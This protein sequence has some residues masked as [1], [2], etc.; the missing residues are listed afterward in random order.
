M[1]CAACSAVL[2]VI[3]GPLGVGKSTTS[4][5]LLQL[6]LPREHASSAVQGRCF[7]VEGDYSLVANDTDFRDESF[8][9]AWV[10]CVVAQVRHMLLSHRYSRVVINYVFERRSHL[11]SLVDALRA[12]CSE[13]CTCA[14]QSTVRRTHK[15]HINK[16][17]EDTNSPCGGASGA[18]A[19]ASGAGA[20][21]GAGDT[22]AAH[23][24]KDASDAGTDTVPRD[25]EAPLAGQG[26]CVLCFRLD[27]TEEF[28]VER[29]VTR[30]TSQAEW[31]RTRCVELR[32]VLSEA[33]PCG[34]LGQVVDTTPC[35][36][37]LAG[38]REGHCSAAAVAGKLVDASL[39]WIAPGHSPALPKRLDFSE[40]YV[41]KVVS[42]IKTATTRLF[43]GGVG[44]A[45]QLARGD[46]A[47]ASCRQGGF[48]FAVLGI[49]ARHETTMDKL[50]EEVAIRD[51]FNSADDLRAALR[52]HYAGIKHTDRVV[53]F[54]F[55]VVHW[56]GRR[57][58]S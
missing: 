52:H 8:H 30:N 2:F 45:S 41:S 16:S 3:G 46:L 5:E 15:E 31:E 21:A 33:G 44:I 51:G 11:V 40:V 20:G 47:L 43:R 57:P 12:L 22:S 50:T 48:V 4:E 56:L 26:P 53:V 7:L 34:E 32:R 35:A 1:D 9:A 19:G 36:G 6:L 38:A 39:R 55:C 14:S 23:G 27:A 24:S 18:G 10:S 58:W 13:L 17:D 29:V 28:L 25:V 49:Q 37:C 54:E 42:G